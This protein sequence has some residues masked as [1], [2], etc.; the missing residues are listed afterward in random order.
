MVEPARAGTGEGGEADPAPA[1]WQIALAAFA[2]AVYL[3]VHLGLNPAGGDEDGAAVDGMASINQ[4][5][6]LIGG[7]AVAVRARRACLAAA[8]DVWPI[9]PLLALAAGSALWSQ[10]PDATLRRSLTLA[11]L[12]I[13]A[14]QAHATLGAAA[15]CRIQVGVTWLVALASFAAALLV[16]ASGLD[17][18]DYAGAVRG[19]FTQKNSLGD[20]MVVGMLALCGLVLARRRLAWGDLATLALALVTCRLAQSTTAFVL[21]GLVAGATLVCLLLFDGGAL[22][23]FGLATLAM[24]IALAAF[25]VVAEPVDL[26]GVLGKDGTLTG[27]SQIW[28]AVHDAIA[29]RPTLGYGYSAFWIPDTHAAEDVWAA[30]GWTAPSAHNGYLETRLDLG[31]AGLAALAGLAAATLA[32]AALALGAGRGGIAAWAVI[33]LAVMAIYNLDESLLPHPGAHLLQWL[34]AAAACNRA[35]RLRGGCRPAPAARAVPRPPPR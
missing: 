8:V 29:R 30:I 35:W 3:G 1:G 17:T 33:V 21:C 7:L 9:L 6:V 25:T 13:F 10:A 12:V 28:A 23:G 32:L 24:G 16:P 19:V 34:L 5:I 15:L 27:R 14:V 2:A 31:A 26:Y 22:A 20:A 18:G 11:T 4:A